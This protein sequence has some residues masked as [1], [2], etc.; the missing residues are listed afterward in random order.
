MGWS[1]E[2]NRLLLSPIFVIVL[3]K[4][5]QFGGYVKA[6]PNTQCT[7]PKAHLILVRLAERMKEVSRVIHSRPA[8]AA[9]CLVP[10][11][12]D[13]RPYHISLV[14]TLHIPKEGLRTRQLDSPKL[15]ARDVEQAETSLISRKERKKKNLTQKTPP[16]P[17]CSPTF[18]AKRT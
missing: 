3:C 15:W 7:A 12:R 18:A 17:V 8:R 10:K 5:F 6:K 16:S 4:T 1:H 13:P 9:R 11:G 2:F 14:K